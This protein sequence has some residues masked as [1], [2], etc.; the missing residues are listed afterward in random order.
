M[1]LKV[2]L[3]ADDQTLVILGRPW[4]VAKKDRDPVP[5]VGIVT[6]QE[7]VISSLSLSCLLSLQEALRGRGYINASYIR[8]PKY[9]PD[10]TVAPA[11]YRDTPEFIA[12]QGPG[13]HTIADFLT[14]AYEQRSPLVVM[15]CK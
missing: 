12:A 8:R 15:L 13:P 11:S 14:M 1:S 2:P 5:K 6:R 3:C 9:Q 10:G 4:S 7:A